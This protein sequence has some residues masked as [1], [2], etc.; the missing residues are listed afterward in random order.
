M[1]WQF[2]SMKIMTLFLT[3]ALAATVLAEDDGK[4]TI[5]I[6]SSV[7]ATVAREKGDTGTV[8]DFRKVNEPDGTTYIV[9]IVANG[10]TWE[11]SLDA[12]GRVIRKRLDTG[13]SGPRLLRV[14]GLPAIV[15]ETMQREAGAGVIGEIELIEQKTRYIGEATIGKRIYRI[16]VDADGLLLNKEYIGEED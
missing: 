11:L 9:G 15:R 4:L 1:H 6:P 3:L 16:E 2:S 13:D 10:K 5:A 14:E 8:R 12:S 7:Q